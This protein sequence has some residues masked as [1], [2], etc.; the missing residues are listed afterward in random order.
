M[1]IFLI[2]LG[3]IVILVVIIVLLIINWCGKAAKEIEELKRNSDE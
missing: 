3:G 2:I 1:K